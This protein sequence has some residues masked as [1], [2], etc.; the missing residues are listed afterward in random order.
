MAADSRIGELEASCMQSL[1]RIVNRK[2]EFT[3]NQARESL[4]SVMSESIG[5]SRI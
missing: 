2:I 1:P 4:D 3:P 5:K